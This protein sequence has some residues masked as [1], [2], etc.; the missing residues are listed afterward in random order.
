MPD[1]KPCL[2]FQADAE[3]AASFYVSLS[4]APRSRA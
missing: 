1:I 3:E 2:W 4:R